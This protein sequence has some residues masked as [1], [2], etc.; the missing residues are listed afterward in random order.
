MS[1]RDHLDHFIGRTVVDVT[2]H[3]VGVDDPASAHVTLLFDD[4]S[5]LRYPIGEDG[6]FWWGTVNNCLDH[7]GCIAAEEPVPDPAVLIR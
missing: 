1:I 2:S 3:D 5:Y 4:G 6:G 7:V